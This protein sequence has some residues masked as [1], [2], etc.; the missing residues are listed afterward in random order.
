VEAGRIRDGLRTVGGEVERIY[1]LIPTRFVV[2]KWEDIERLVLQPFFE[3]TPH[4]ALGSR[5]RLRQAVERFPVRVLEGSVGTVTHSD[6]HLISVHLDD[7]IEEL[8]PWGNE[9]LWED[10]QVNGVQADLEVIP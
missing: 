5:V 7:E 6:R 3:G 1:S 8:T 2:E 10:D 9:L 4:I